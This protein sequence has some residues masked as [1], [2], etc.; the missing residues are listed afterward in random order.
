MIISL[1]RKNYQKEFYTF[2][3]MVPPGAYC[4][5]TDNRTAPLQNPFISCVH[6]VFSLYSGNPVMRVIIL[7]FLP[8]KHTAEYTA[9]GFLFIM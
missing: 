1:Y 7:P 3:T 5:M 8:C 2:F 9:T 4:H 6:G